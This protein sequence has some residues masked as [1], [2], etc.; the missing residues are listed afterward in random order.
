MSNVG[1]VAAQ[2]AN[3]LTTP[4]NVE[5]VFSTY[6][7]DGN[8]TARSIVNGID[9]AGEGGLVW[10]KARGAAYDNVL[11]DTERGA[12]QWLR[13]NNTGASATYYSNTGLTSFNSDGFSLGTDPTGYYVNQSAGG[14]YASWTFR[15]APKFFDVV[16][17]TGDGTSNRAISHNLGTTVGSIF[18]KRTNAVS[19]WIVWHRSLNNSGSFYEELALNTT[20]AASATNGRFPTTEP[21]STEFYV[22]QYNPVNDPDG[23]YVAYLFAHNDGDGNFGPTGDQDIIKCGSYV[24]D[25]TDYQKIDLGFEAQWVI[26]KRVSGTSNWDISDNMRGLTVDDNR[27]LEA[28]SSLAETTETFKKVY[29]NGFMVSGNN[30]DSNAAT[31]T[32]IY[33]AIRRGPMAVPESATDVFA[34]AFDAGATNPTYVS[35]FVTDMGIQTNT[36]GYN[37]R[38]SSRLTS[39]RFLEADNTGAESTSASNYTWD[40]MNGWNNQTIGSTWLSWMWRRAPNFFDVVAY[41]GTGVAGRTVSHN[42]GVVPEMIWVK[43]RSGSTSNW[44]VYH[45]GLNVNS[46]NAPETDFIR[47]DTSQAA[48]DD[49]GAFWNSTAPTDSNFTVGSSVGVNGSSTTYI[50]YLFASLAGVSKV[51]SL[52]HT[53]GSNTTVDCGFSSGAR[54]V[55]LKLADGTENWLMFDTARGLTSSTAPAL[56]LNLTNAEYDQNQVDPD[57]SGF[58][59]K[60]GMFTSGTYIYYAIA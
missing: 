12:N 26:T 9:L 53:I 51:G 36:T 7:Y 17:Y 49:G 5:D 33:I 38:V 55:L 27:K 47:L 22:N 6:L 13:S 1:R 56:F 59:M 28:N 31:H 58:I 29:N 30:S 60:S 32:Y 16:T 4:L 15:K 24:G 44:I 42:L 14:G 35:G 43:Q 52:S 10:I 20:A 18:I 40:F 34:T 45:S 25:A 8:A 11:F 19:D 54:F 21:T 50:A 39:G 57:S 41:T 46:D 23:T 48:A 37:K 3:T 2:A